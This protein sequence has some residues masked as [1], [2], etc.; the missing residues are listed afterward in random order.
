MDWRKNKGWLDSAQVGVKL[1]SK[2]KKKIQVRVWVY[3]DTEL[4]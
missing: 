4:R 1:W 3:E 2:K